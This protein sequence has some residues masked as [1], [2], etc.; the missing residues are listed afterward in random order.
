VGE[1]TGRLSPVVRMQCR[2][3]YGARVSKSI[4][5]AV[6]YH[7]SEDSSSYVFSIGR[8]RRPTWAFRSAA[9]GI[10]SDPYSAVVFHHLSSLPIFFDRGIVPIINF[11]AAL[12]FPLH[13]P[14]SGQIN[15]RL[16]NSAWQAY[17]CN[18]K[19]RG[20]MHAGYAGYC[21]PRHIEI[22]VKP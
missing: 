16:P 12:S 22:D 7:G 2:H 6:E 5:R 4:T 18:I 8:S 13:W 21:I 10:S 20:E 14:M 3:R 15:C 17:S 1:Y 19:G 9:C 11:W